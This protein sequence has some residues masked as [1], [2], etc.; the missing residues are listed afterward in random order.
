MKNEIYGEIILGVRMPV[1]A[2]NER[3]AMLEAN[4][5]VSNEAS[6]VVDIMVIDHITGKVHKID[7]IDW[8]IKW[9][10]FFREGEVI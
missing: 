7:I 5:K 9:Q 2:N 1:S 6:D 10:K 4:Y 3:L 8:N